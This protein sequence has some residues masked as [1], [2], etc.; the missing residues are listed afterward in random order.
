MCYNFKIMMIYI[1]SFIKNNFKQ[2]YVLIRN[3][4]KSYYYKYYIN[5]KLSKFKGEY[6][7]NFSFEGVN[8]KIWLNRDNGFVDEQIFVYGLYEYE[9]LK[10]HKKFLKEGD[11]YV[12]VGA[13]IGDTSLFA[14]KI[15][16]EKGKVLAFE[17]I[18]SLAKQMEKSKKENKLPQLTI[19]NKA[20]SDKEGKALIYKNKSN[21]GAS[22][23][24]D[25][26]VTGDKEEIELT[27]AKQELDNLDKID[28]IK[29]DVEGHEEKVFKVLES[30]ILKF[31]PK[32]IFEF[33]P[34]MYEDKTYILNFLQKN[35]YLIFDIEKNMTQIKD[36]KVW[37]DEFCFNQEKQTNIFC[38]SA[39]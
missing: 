33:S 3:I 8:F 30:Y 25:I 36:I 2:L 34:Y 23:L 39:L 6:L 38:K 12:D 21:I 14:A 11:Y 19:I 35:N 4:F 13:N 22:S 27:T 37:F 28:F 29:V 15:V 31:K 16:G 24:T 20:I 5:Q 10:V 17:P 32:I 9:V 7:H 26:G 18:K 1:K